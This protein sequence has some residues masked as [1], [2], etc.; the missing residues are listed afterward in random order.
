[1]AHV[2][3]SKTAVPVAP[4][5]FV[6]RPAL[7][8]ALDEGEDSALTLVCA[9]PGYGKTLLLADWVRRHDGPAAWVSLDEED[10]DPRRLWSSVLAALAACP[11]VPMTSSLRT[12]VVP[13]TTVGIDFLTDL[14]DALDGPADARPA[15]ARRR[16]PPPQPGD[17][18]RA[19][20]APAQPARAP[21]GSSSRAGS[22]R[23]SR[24]R[25]SASRSG[26]ASCGPRS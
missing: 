23:R 18:A 9:P 4:P 26:C 8:T 6:P 13:R 19:P 20:P 25:G 3:K 14:L 22:T 5:E 16:A 7:L 21:S 1:M 24:W 2:P 10:D 12:L 11:A 15:R 17:P